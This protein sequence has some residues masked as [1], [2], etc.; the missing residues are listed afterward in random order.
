MTA[1]STRIAAWLAVAAIFAAPLF[2]SAFAVTLLN[3]I[4]VYA[5][6]AMGLV[7]LTGIGGLVSF[8]QAAFVGVGAYSTAWLTTVEGQSPWLGLALAVVLT[9][10]IAAALGAVTLRLEGHFLSLSTLAWGL[11]IGFC[12]GNI[13][14]LG[15]FT[16]IASVPPIRLGS[17]ALERSDQ[18]YYL[19][20][21]IV[22]AAAI[23]LH[24]LLDSRSGRAMRALRGGRL[25]VGSLGVNPFRVRMTIFVIAALLAALS[26]WLYAHLSRYVSPSPFN[27]EMGIEYLMMAMVGGASSPIGGIVGAAAISILK[28]SIQDY[29]P[30]IVKGAAA[31]LE[32]VVF[33]ALFILFLQH[34]RDGVVPYVARAL[35]KPGPVPPPPAEPLSRRPR[36]APGSRLL[37]VR[38]AERRFSGLLAVNRLSFDVAA[39]EILALIGPNGAG[40]ST[41][42]NLLTGALPLTSGSIRF[43]GREIRSASQH[44]IARW[45]IARTFQ[46]VKLRPR[47]TVIDNVLL[48]AYGRL[49]SGVLAGALCWNRGEEARARH[50]AMVQLERVGLA[51]RAFDLAGNLPLGAQR[52]LEIARALIADPILLVLDEPAAGLRRREKLALAELLQSLRAERLTILLVEHDMEFVMNLVDR[53]VVMDFGVKLSEGAPAEVRD[54]PRVREAYLGGVA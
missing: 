42:F 8:G 50:E 19:I 52:L 24:N 51:A 26:G 44:A 35:P 11:A 4:G 45:G 17:L 54:D 38:D 34:A 12:F 25:L 21:G 49:S 10:A 43:N 7:L 16:G 39:A 9:C 28:N 2:V 18:I 23:L 30:L 29:L 6:V 31:Q 13:E 33:S 1:G 41:M 15:N 36:P 47:M 20:W 22:V 46:H 27:A 32:I 48:G 53:V 14:G 37:E 40:K 3:Y 5:L